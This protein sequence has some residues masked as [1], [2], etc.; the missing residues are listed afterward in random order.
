MSWARYQSRG[1]DHYMEVTYE[2]L[3]LETERTLR[4]VCD[5]LDLDF[6][7]AMLDYHERRRERLAEKARDLPKDGGRTQPAEA[8]IASHA[9]AKEPPRADRVGPLEARDERGGRGRVRAGGGR[10]AGRA[11][12]RNGGP[13]LK[14]S[15]VND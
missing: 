14:A 8:R 13:D 6:D 10:P 4:E 11:G 12:L 1:V 5:F 3:I 7:P 9:L 15:R 2:D